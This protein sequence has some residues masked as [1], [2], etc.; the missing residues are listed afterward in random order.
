M[1]KIMEVDELLLKKKPKKLSQKPSE[2]VDPKNQPGKE[3]T[4]EQK[5]KQ[6]L[7]EDLGAL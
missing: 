5:I 3:L 6:E 2:P 7:R 1:E 4:D